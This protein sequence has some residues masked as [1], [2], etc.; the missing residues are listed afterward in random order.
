[1]RK[2]IIIVSIAFSSSHLS[3]QIYSE[4]FKNVQ[5]LADW[6]FVNAS[7]SPTSSESGWFQGN[8]NVF[9]A[10]DG[11]ENSYLAVDFT[12]SQCCV[13]SNWALLPVMELKNGDKLTFYTRTLAGSLRPDR[14][15]VRISTDGF[16]SVWPEGPEDLGSYTNLLL[17]I[18][19]SLE[20]R[21]YPEVWEEQTV[22]LS[23]LD[24]PTFVQF[25]FRYYITGGG[26]NG[27]NGHYIGIDSVVV[28]EL[29]AVDDLAKK[30]IKFK[31]AN[32]YLW[33][34]SKHLLDEIAVYNM[35]G[36]RLL[37]RKLKNNEGSIPLDGLAP[38][39]YIFLAGVDGHR[40]RKKF[41]VN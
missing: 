12:S 34:T 27:I 22:E 33:L 9:P 25:A 38:G 31:V 39:V 37:Y 35:V 21:G 19:E 10:Q 5:N 8:P 32:G 1:M 14:L 20:L 41:A 18:N 7:I 36:R 11:P 28:D 29:L 3:S 40:I 30:G 4:G 23:G 26:I 6:N 13:I 2:F 17:T 15:E 24:G 16:N